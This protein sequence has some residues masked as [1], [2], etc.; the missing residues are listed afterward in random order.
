[1]KNSGIAIASLIGGML[2][3]SALTLLFAPQ[4]GN[5]TR[6]KI[7][8][9]IDEEADKMR[10]EIEKVRCKCEERAATHEMEE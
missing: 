4:S 10:G 3:G 2:V 8:E 1:M 9:F 5:E 6:R 7:K